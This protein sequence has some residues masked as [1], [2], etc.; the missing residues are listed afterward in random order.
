MNIVSLNVRSW[1][2]SG[3]IFLFALTLCVPAS[4]QPVERLPDHHPKSRID[5]GLVY[6]LPA[7]PHHRIV[8]PQLRR[9]PDAVVM[10]AVNRDLNVEEQKLRAERS[11]CIADHEHTAS[12]EQSSRV[13][14]LTRDIFSI[15][16]EAFVYCGGVHPFEGYE[17]LTYNMRTGKRFDFDRDSGEI[18]SAGRLP[19]KEL[20]DLYKQNYPSSYG[21]CHASMIEP[22]SALYL[23]FEPTGLAILPNLPHVIA[24]CGPEIT[25]SYQELRPLLKEGNPFQALIGP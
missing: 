5:P 25:V 13:A 19:V 11:D 18:F 8:L 6:L 9:F 3:S 12:W 4:T 24:A 20:I 16:N 14:I 22:D 10:K 1:V 2:A 21:D 7:N 17:P 15:E 23:H